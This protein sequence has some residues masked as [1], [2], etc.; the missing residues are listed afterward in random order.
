[1]I[2]NPLPKKTDDQVSG[3]VMDITAAQKR[4]ERIRL[5][6]RE[7]RNIIE[8]I[9]AFVG[10]ALRFKAVKVRPGWQTDGVAGAGG[11]EL[12]CGPP[13]IVTFPARGREGVP[14]REQRVARPDETLT[15][16]DAG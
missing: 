2:A 7:L 11:K 10:T 3:M 5:N 12:R 6:E 9:P 14:R 15:V 8:T 4:E 16:S 1:M 13:E